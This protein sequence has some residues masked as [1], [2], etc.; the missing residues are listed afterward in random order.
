MSHRLE[1]GGNT[2]EGRVLRV[3][4]S[5]S[6][7]ERCCAIARKAELSCSA[8]KSALAVL[9]GRGL[10]ERAARSPGQGGPARWR[11][12]AAGRAADQRGY[13]VWPGGVDDA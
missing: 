13:Q 2:S 9:S 1:L 10:I 6:R 3:V 12:T 5:L 8:T 4:L 11:A 7:P